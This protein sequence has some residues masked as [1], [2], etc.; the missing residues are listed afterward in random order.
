MTFSLA[1]ASRSLSRLMPATSPVTYAILTGNCLLFGYSLLWTIR[2]GGGLMAGGGGNPF[3]MLFNLGGINGEVLQVLGASL[4]LPYDLA[5]PWRFVMAVFLHGSL[6]HLGFNMWVLMDVGPM[7]EEI[8]GSARYLFLYAVTGVAGYVLSGL[9][10]HFSIGA[11]GALMG[12]FGL[13]LAVTSRRGSA[14]MQ[15]LR[16]QLIIWVGFIFLMGFTVHGI[17]N[18]AHLGGLAAGF[19]LGRIVAD[20]EPATVGERKR[21]QILGWLT[22]LVILASFAAMLFNYFRPA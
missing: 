13:L 3:S 9:L 17:D 20:R 18:A 12:L 21:A 22:A 19:G 11:S 15:M 7:V 14:A 8:Y 2:L 10:G 5:Q 16:G 4:P 6:I 1:A